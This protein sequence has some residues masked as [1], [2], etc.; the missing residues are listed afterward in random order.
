MCTALMADL[1]QGVALVPD[2]FIAGEDVTI[3]CTLIGEG[4][5]I[6]RLVNP[7][8]VVS[9]PNHGNGEQGGQQV[10]EASRVYRTL[11][12][13]PLKTSDANVDYTCQ[14]R[15]VVGTFFYP[16]HPIPLPIILNVTS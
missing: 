6:G 12:F 14:T 5:L 3:N 8:F 10:I 13:T 9:W 1:F 16:I 2:P 4:G 11:T 15:F 7:F